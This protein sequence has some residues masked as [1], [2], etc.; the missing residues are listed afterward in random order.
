M[1]TRGIFDATTRNVSSL[2]GLRSSRAG[3]ELTMSV[4]LARKIGTI[5]RWVN[6]LAMLGD[7]LTKFG[8]RKVF[9]QFLAR[10]QSWRLIH[11]KEFTAGRK[12]KK[13]EFEKAAKDLETFFVSEV[14]KLARANKWLWQDEEDSRSMG[15]ESFQLDMFEHPDMT[16]PDYSHGIF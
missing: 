6:G 9:L 10:G 5:F 1:D 11:D 4:Q 2:H 13:R 8:E 12:L 15:D 3:Y 16:N 14:G 7:C